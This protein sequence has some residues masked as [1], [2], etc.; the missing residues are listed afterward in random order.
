[1]KIYLSG[2]ITG[3]DNYKAK[4]EKTSLELQIRFPNAEIINPVELC[5]DISCNARW[6]EYMKCCIQGLIQ[7]D[8]IYM[9]ADWQF[10]KGSRLEHRIAENLGIE[11][12]FE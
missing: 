1:M 2:K 8:T 3:T 4:F 5:K 10:S 12:I 6:S 11:T 7:C 9:T